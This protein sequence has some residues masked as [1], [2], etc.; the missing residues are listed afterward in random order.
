MW[1]GRMVLPPSG[2][3]VAGA[4]GM[5][6]G[7]LREKTIAA[8]EHGAGAGDGASLGCGHSSLEKQ[9]KRMLAATSCDA[10]AVYCWH[11]CMELTAADSEL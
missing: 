5:T 3:Q 6:Y 1:Y 7:T 4:G 9:N 11:R 2:A 8:T 10:G